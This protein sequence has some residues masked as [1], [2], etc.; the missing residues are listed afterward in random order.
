MKKNMKKEIRFVRDVEKCGLKFKINERFTV[1][2]IK[3]G[4]CGEIY[5]N[6]Y[7]QNGTMSGAFSFYA[8]V[9]FENGKVMSFSIDYEIH[10]TGNAE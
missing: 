6:M 10:I 3:Y 7:P 5:E 2:V 1:D 9:E 4:I 8:L